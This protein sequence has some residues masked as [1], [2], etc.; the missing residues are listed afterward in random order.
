MMAVENNPAYAS[1]IDALKK[2]LGKENAALV[3]KYLEQENAIVG[4][5]VDAEKLDRALQSLFGQGATSVICG[6]G[7][8]KAPNETRPLARA[9]GR[10]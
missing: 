10:Q 7:P 8:K 9:A 6:L 2:M 5:R 1:L 4:S 3:V